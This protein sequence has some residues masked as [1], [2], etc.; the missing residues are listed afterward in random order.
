MD[1]ASAV[2][3]DSTGAYVV[4]STAGSLSGASA[5]MFDGFVRKYSLS[6]TLLWGN[7]FGTPFNDESYGVATDTTGA[8]VVGYA[9]GALGGATFAGGYDAVIR[10]YSPTGALTW[11]Q[12][13]GTSADDRFT[14]VT[15]D[16]SGVYVTG[17]TR[18][19][20]GGQTSGGG[21]DTLVRAYTQDG[22]PVWTRQWGGAGDDQA[23]SVTADANAVYT[24]GETSGSLPGAT[25][26]GGADAFVAAWSKTP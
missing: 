26:L 10:K 21:I 25:S 9:E 23:Y 5:G 14:G 18:G 1:L 3:V 6:G 8:Y 13:F 17:W 11:N 20:V 16:S 19:T 4:G 2:A 12:E 15:A 24:V 22:A 7:Q